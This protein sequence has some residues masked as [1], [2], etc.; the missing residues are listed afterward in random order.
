MFLTLGR[1]RF[2]WIPSICLIKFPGISPEPAPGS[3]AGHPSSGP[4]P[5][6]PEPPKPSQRCTGLSTTLAHVECSRTPLRSKVWISMPFPASA[7]LADP[8]WSFQSA[9]ATRFLFLWAD[10][11]AYLCNDT[12]FFH[13][14]P[15]TS[16]EWR[17]VRK[18]TLVSHF[19]SFA[20][21]GEP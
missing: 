13:G 5:G 16:S 14:P 11:V 1:L 12:R 18:R 15:L 21:K 2:L 6:P 10:I 7:A 8:A 9:I 3:P 4:T 20:K 19:K 17:K